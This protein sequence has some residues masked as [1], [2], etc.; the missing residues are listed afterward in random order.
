[1]LFNAAD[2]TKTAAL[3]KGDAKLAWDNLLDR[4][5]PRTA[6]VEGELRREFTRSELRDDMIN[7]DV[8]FMEIEHTTSRCWGSMRR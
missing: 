7:P 2:E 6:L 4:Y 3:P 8:Y 1:M 5:Q